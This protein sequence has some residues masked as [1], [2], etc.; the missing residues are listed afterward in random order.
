MGVTSLSDSSG[1]I[2]CL[3]FKAGGCKGVSENAAILMR[4][5]SLMW[6]FYPCQVSELF[7]TFYLPLAVW[8]RREET[9]PWCVLSDLK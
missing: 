8:D 6:S 5:S 9:H 1:I 4:K 7:Q 3:A 2:T